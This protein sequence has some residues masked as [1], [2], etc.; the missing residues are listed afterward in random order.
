MGRH[1]SSANGTAKL[2][3]L[4]AITS[5][6]PGAL[7]QEAIDLTKVKTPTYIQAGREDHIA[8]V[9]S[10]WKLQDHFT[11]PVKFLLAGSGHIAG[12]VNPPVQQ[13]YQY[14]TNDAKVGSLEEFI[15]GATETKGSWWPDW[16][17]WL[18]H[19]SDKMVAV[20]GARVPG[21]G[22]LKALNLPGSYVK[23]AEG[24]GGVGDSP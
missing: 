13:K 19:G 12:V 18:K 9:E 2:C 17:S 24:V 23:R 15:A 14:W 6:R 1:K 10:V 8:P 22:T 16:L 20:K 4:T 3:D 5:C 7:C 11:G 21:E